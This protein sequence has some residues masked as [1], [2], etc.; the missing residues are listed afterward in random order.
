MNIYSYSFDRYKHSFISLHAEIC[1]FSDGKTMVPPFSNL[2]H[3]CHVRFHPCTIVNKN[4]SVALVYNILSKSICI[5]SILYMYCI[6]CVNDNM[7]FVRYYVYIQNA[8][9]YSYSYLYSYICLFHC[10]YL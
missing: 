4:E 8:L 9:S 10:I 6:M 7:Y 2:D 1:Q 5:I 3:L